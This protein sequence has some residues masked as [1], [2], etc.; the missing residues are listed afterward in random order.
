MDLVSESRT[1]TITLTGDELTDLWNI[2]TIYLQSKEENKVYLKLA[3]KFD[4][5]VDGLL[6]D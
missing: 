2:T 5:F 3:E 6:N 1:Y 4:C